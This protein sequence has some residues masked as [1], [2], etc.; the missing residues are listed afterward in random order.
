[1]DKEQATNK[2]LAALSGNPE[3]LTTKALS[4]IAKI[5]EAQVV[6]LLVG[7]DYANKGTAT[8]G[9][10]VNLPPT[11]WKLKHYVP[12]SAKDEDLKRRVAEGSA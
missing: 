9:G 5:N 4:E 1:M 7:S 3:G 8:Q 11:L 6:H 10:S 12:G 2:M